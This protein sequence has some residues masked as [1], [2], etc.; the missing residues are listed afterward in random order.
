M[1]LLR[2]AFYGFAIGSLLLLIALGLGRLLPEGELYAYTL[3]WRSEP[4]VYLMDIGRSVSVAVTKNLPRPDAYRLAT[5]SPDASQ[6]AVTIAEQGDGNLYLLDIW[7]GLLNPLLTDSS[8]DEQA[9]WSPDG[10]WIAYSS[11][12]EGDW[13]IYK[14]EVA[15]GITTRLTDLLE[16]STQPSWS[17]DG[18]RIVFVNGQNLFIMAADCPEVNGMCGSNAQQITSSA[19]S[20]LLPVWSPDGTQIAFMS[21]RSGRTEIYVMDAACLDRAEGCLE[22]NPHHLKRS[23]GRLH[24]LSWTRER[25]LLLF[26]SDQF[27]RAGLY[28]LQPDC[29]LMGS[30]KLEPVV[31]VES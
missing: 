23:V 9:A 17:P 25:G 14:V 16:D 31:L 15:T 29:D 24:T 13:D 21:D 8:Y 6:I 26:I 3:P 20:D 2:L 28:S 11:V 22:Q 4:A 7:S 27:G 5:L 19:S 18:Q 12:L 1:K 10:R 30:C